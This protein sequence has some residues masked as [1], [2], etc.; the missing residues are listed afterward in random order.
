M[1]GLSDDPDAPISENDSPSEDNDADN[2]S[3]DDADA[4]TDDD[5]P[6]V[7]EP[8]YY[9]FGERTPNH[10]IQSICRDTLARFQSSNQ[11]SQLWDDEG[12][13]LHL[14][15]FLAR[16]FEPADRTRLAIRKRLLSEYR[17]QQLLSDP[18][19]EQRSGNGTPWYVVPFC[20]YVYMS[21]ILS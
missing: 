19:V 14:E 5:P 9:G 8:E 18:L 12:G 1:S 10:R 17:V 20:R 21:T 4:H 13:R 7:D 2:A 11:L 3:E 15:R 6:P 16:L